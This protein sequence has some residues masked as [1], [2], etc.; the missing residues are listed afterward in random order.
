VSFPPFLMQVFR[1]T[2]SSMT[3]LLHAT[4]SKQSIY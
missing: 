2:L 4:E 3:A 1:S